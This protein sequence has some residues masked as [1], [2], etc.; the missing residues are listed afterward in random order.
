MS[1]LLLSIDVVAANI[2]KYKDLSCL[3]EEVCALVFEVRRSRARLVGLGPCLR[4]GSA[5]KAMVRGLA[6][7][8]A[9]AR[10]FMQRVLE[11]G[12]LS[13]KVAVCENMRETR[14]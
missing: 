13:P 5:T 3:P 2:D 11:L 4:S 10:L 6:F 9:V 14:V 7:T 8:S 1:L 12:K